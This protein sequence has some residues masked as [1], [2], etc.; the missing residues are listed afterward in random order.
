MPMTMGGR[1]RELRQRRGM[2]QEELGEILY[3]KKSTISAYENDAIDIK[4]SVLSEIAD[5]L[6]I[7]PGY[8]FEKKDPDPVADEAVLLLSSIK[9]PKIKLAALEH[10]RITSTLGM[11]F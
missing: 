3:M 11:D 2:T 4:C 5:A 8:F 10:I 6:N 1:I 9:N 7:S